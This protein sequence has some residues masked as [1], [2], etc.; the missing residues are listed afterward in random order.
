MAELERWPSFLEIVGVYHHFS[1]QIY[2]YIRDEPL[3]WTQRSY[4]R[5]AVRETPPT[6]AAVSHRG[7][8][9]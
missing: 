4:V 6:T 3:S 5:Q 1:A 9:P 7:F 8:L 2:G